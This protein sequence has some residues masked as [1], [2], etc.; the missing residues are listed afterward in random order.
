M[1]WHGR[2]QPRPAGSGRRILVAFAGALLDEV[3]L[4]A[5]LR[6]ARAEEATLVAAYLIVVPLSFPIDSPLHEEV[7]VALPILEAIEHAAAKAGVAVD[8]RMERGRSRRDAL[9]RLW[10]VEEFDRVILPAAV[11][12]GAGFEGR[13]LSWALAHAPTELVVLRPSPREAR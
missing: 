5:A 2:K 8:A 4:A 1:S 13:D 11:D 3:V 7:G 12:G 9:E 6:I 10:S